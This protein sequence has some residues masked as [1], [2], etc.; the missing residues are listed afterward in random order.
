MD[1]DVRHRDT[2]QL[3]P[4]HN[5]HGAHGLNVLLGSGIASKSGCLGVGE[6]HSEYQ[7]SAELWERAGGER[8]A[9]RSDQYADGHE[10][11]HVERYAERVQSCQCGVWYL[12]ISEQTRLGRGV[13]AKMAFDH[14]DF[15]REVHFTRSCRSLKHPLA[16][17]WRESVSLCT[18]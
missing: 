18:R 13:G 8:L 6:H 2:G 5:E 7:P 14:S 9:R 10:S 15:G 11:V 17:I 4:L 1:H 16:F 3:E 12:D